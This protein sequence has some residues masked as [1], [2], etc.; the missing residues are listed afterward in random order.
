MGLCSPF[1]FLY[2]LKYFFSIV[3]IC[4]FLNFLW[5]FKG[6]DR[7]QQ[8]QVTVVVTVWHPFSPLECLK[9]DHRR[10]TVCLAVL[11]NR[12]RFSILG[13]WYYNT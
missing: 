2:S 4:I 10:Y 3:V 11:D 9:V 5:E 13:S 1:F 6:R 8:A 7:G 12:V